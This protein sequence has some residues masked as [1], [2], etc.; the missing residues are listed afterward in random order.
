MHKT[1]TL[2]SALHYIWKMAQLS[3][4]AMSYGP[5]GEHPPMH[6]LSIVL[7]QMSIYTPPY[8]RIVQQLK[9]LQNFVG[10]KV[11]LEEE[12]REIL[13]AVRMGT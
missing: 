6:S 12:E 7:S 4:T 8:T 9:L 2:P 1:A 5:Q 13:R 3:L 10:I 11:N